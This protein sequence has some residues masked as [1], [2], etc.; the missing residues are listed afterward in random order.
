VKTTSNSALS[1]RGAL[2][3]T[4]MLA[5]IVISG[6]AMALP[7]MARQ[8]GMACS[9]C[10]ISSFGPSLTPYGR[11]FKLTGY[12]SGSN[13]SLPPVSAMALGGFT[14]T[15][16][17]QESPPAG[18]S[19]N[20]NFA[21]NQLSAFY[22]G[23]IWDKIGAF[24]QL[25]YDGVANTV[26]LDLTDIRY[27]DQTDIMDKD[28]IFGVTANNAPTVGDIWNTTPVWGFPYATS[29]L[30]PTPGAAAV[31][32]GPLIATSGGGSVYAMID[33]MLYVD[34]GAYTTLSTRMQQ[35][36]GVWA[37]GHMGID[38]GAPYW[39]VA[40]Q[41]QWGAHYAMI[42]SYG[43][44]A[45]VYPEG[46]ASMGTDSYLD[47][48]VDMT[49][50]YLADMKHIF[51]IK[52]NFI[53]ERQGLNASK[54][55]GLAANSSGSLNTF[56]INGAYT[57]EQTYQLT[58]GYNLISGSQDYTRYSNGYINGSPNSEYYIVE[59]DYVPFGKHD[60]PYQP[61]INLRIGL[62]Y[63]AYSRFNGTTV[64]AQNNNTLF[65]SGWLAF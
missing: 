44:Q 36:L 63:I 6:K 39:R 22:G 45:N 5:P 15:Q 31:I 38:G 10:H 65:L 49:Y 25:T 41:H 50:Q 34:A 48:A 51:E 27:S 7:S 35:G 29:P 59:A 47:T 53:N 14:N 4:I 60:S 12:T 9:A 1:I 57:F 11:H 26:G 16:S 37:N 42:G 46:D 19:A 43:L 54:N 13:F 21:L 24:S 8:T 3:G 2:I 30:A 33:N 32:D 20:N 23:R 56:R 64:N 52:S 61:W 28:I 58:F 62:Q 17:N 55:L 40:L 18:Y